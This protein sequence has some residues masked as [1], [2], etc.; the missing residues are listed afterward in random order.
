MWWH[1]VQSQD[2]TVCKVSKNFFLP[3]FSI[4]KFF[5]FLISS[6][7]GFVQILLK[8]LSRFPREE[9]RERS[10]LCITFQKLRKEKNVLQPDGCIPWFLQNAVY[11]LSQS[12]FS[13]PIF[14]CLL[15]TILTDIK[16]V[17]FWHFLEKRCARIIL[18]YFDNY[19]LYWQSGKTKLFQKFKPDF[20]E[21]SK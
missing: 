1:F 3:F 12:T 19:T 2:S 18:Y 17:S 20:N 9:R 15:Y 21:K 8:I 6:I 5:Y 16:S 4:W 14:R 13:N 7:I 10:L 11:F